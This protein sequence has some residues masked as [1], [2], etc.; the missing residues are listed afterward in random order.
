MTHPKAKQFTLSHGV[1]IRV[2][3]LSLP[4]LGPWA[5]SSAAS[6][7]VTGAWQRG[8]TEMET[9]PNNSNTFKTSQNFIWDHEPSHSSLPLKQVTHKQEQWTHIDPLPMFILLKLFGTW[10]VIW[11]GATLQVWCRLSSS[12][13]A[14][15]PNPWSRGL[16]LFGKCLEQK[17]EENRHRK[18]KSS[19]LSPQTVH[20]SIETKASLPA[21]WFCT[22][23]GFWRNIWEFTSCLSG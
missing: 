10:A 3:A 4:H 12:S 15:W 13:P 11:V 19:T 6:E 20:Y 1:S 8:Q 23:W 2:L 21:V 14:V 9:D 17:A 18:W 5:A 16:C 22:S 7:A